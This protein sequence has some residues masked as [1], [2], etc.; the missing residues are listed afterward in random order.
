MPTKF[1][2]VY[3]RAIFKFTDYSFLDTI[4][5]FKEALLQ[6]YLLAAIADFQHMCT[7]VD[8]TDYDL[9]N[10]QFSVELDSEIIE[11][12]SWGIAYYWI[13]ARALNSELLRNKIHNKDYTSYSPANLL[14]EVQ[15]LRST[16]E[17]EFKGRMRTYSFRHGDI[18]TWK[19]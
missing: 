3:D 15:S 19:V 11:I 9:E 2:D 4:T 14:K 13:S 5:E 17:Q 1:T 12:L 6:Q 16:I 18:D 8:L 7:A 10:K